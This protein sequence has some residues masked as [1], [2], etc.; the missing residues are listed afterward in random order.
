MGTNPYWETP[1]SASYED[2]EAP[3]WNE[4]EKVKCLLPLNTGIFQNDK[5]FPVGM[6]DGL[7]VEIIL[8]QADK[9]IKQLDTTLKNRKL[10]GIRS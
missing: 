4:F 10:W 2:D 3:D 6:T 8:E 1:Q 9:C 7:I 5:I